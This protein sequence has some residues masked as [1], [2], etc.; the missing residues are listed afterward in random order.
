VVENET[1]PNKA[2]DIIKDLVPAYAIQS[3]QSANN[4]KD[5]IVELNTARKA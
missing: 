3:D 4:F 2:L 1:D 5:N